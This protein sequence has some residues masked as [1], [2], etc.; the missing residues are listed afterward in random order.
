MDLARIKKI[1]KQNGDKVILV[2]NDEPEVVVM[3]FAE[4]EKLTAH[5]TAHMSGYRAEGHNGVR[6]EEAGFHETEFVRPAAVT[7]GDAFL[8]SE[9]IRL[10]D[11][12]L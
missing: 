10:E 11:L 2:E 12:P 8:P 3:S 9:E 7:V 5:E 4:Y 1:V 6:V